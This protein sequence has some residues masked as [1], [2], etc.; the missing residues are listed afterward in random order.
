M[1]KNLEGGILENFPEVYG[2][3]RRGGGKNYICSF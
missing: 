3:S 1:A 2:G